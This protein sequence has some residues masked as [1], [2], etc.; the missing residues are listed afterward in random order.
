[1]DLITPLYIA[2]FGKVISINRID[3][4]TSEANLEQYDS[5]NTDCVITFIIKDWQTYGIPKY[6]QVDNEAA[7]R[8]GLYHPKTFGKFVRFCLNFGVELIFIPF[9]EPWR[10]GHIESFNDRFEKL[11]WYRF[12]FEDLDHLNQESIKFRDHHNEYQVYR[13]QEFGKQ[14][15]YK[16]T[17][18]F[19][20]KNFNFDASRHL[21]ITTGLMHFIRLV[22]NNGDISILNEKFTLDKKY[23]YEYVWAVLNTKLQS[24]TFYYKA[25][26]D[27]PKEIIKSIPYKLREP[28]KNRIPISRFTKS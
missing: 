23:S 13:K 9:K 26:K 2:G 11:V 12:R 5:K 22:D 8:G 7:F 4:Y 20:P 24:L 6:L 14:Y 3:K 10:N 27:A 21:P 1:M 17:Q 15:A 25:T 19:L 16:Y 18:T 28:V